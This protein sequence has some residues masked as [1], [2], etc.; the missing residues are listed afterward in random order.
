[1][2]LLLSPYAVTGQVQALLVT[3]NTW[4]LSEILPRIHP[5]AA[6]TLPVGIPPAE[7]FARMEFR[8]WMDNGTDLPASSP[9]E[10]RGTP[11]LREVG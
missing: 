6:R 1:M 7:L 10:V 4:F 2:R 8:L 5:V 9:R 3:H 11:G